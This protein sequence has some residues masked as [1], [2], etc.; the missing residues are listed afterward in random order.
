[1]PAPKKGRLYLKLYIMF[2][3]NLLTMLNGQPWA[4]SRAGWTSLLGSLRAHGVS[5]GP[6]QDKPRRRIAT[7]QS[8]DGRK[9]GVL[10]VSGMMVKGIPEDVC[11]WY[12]LANV[13]NIHRG[14]DEA[15]A[16]GVDTLVVHLDS[17]G[18][19]VLGTE[20]AVER[21]DALRAGGMHLIAYTDT[22]ACSAAYWLASACN[23]IAAAP[24]AYVG[25][26]GCICQVVDYSR[27]MEKAG[28]DVHYF[29]SEGSEAK[30]Y[31]A[32]GTAISDEA[33]AA[34]QSSVDKIGARFKAHVAEG[35]PNLAMDDMNGGA[36]PAQDAPKGYVDHI[37][38]PDKRGKM[39]SFST[40]DSL[41]A[42]LSGV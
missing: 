12:G 15:V 37:K 13:D 34:F 33:K 6:M 20:E 3:Q 9:I 41:I 14:A 18:G 4:I 27:A 24:T 8:S 39:S 7:T 36:W 22:M 21:L 17:P 42:L 28:I 10:S 1:M 5:A 25:S 23:E 16:S 2:P 29:V 38:F 31:G 35:R 32:A 11:E 19:M 30:V 26:I 40:V